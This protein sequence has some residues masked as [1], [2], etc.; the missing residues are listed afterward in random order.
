MGPLLILL[1]GVD[2]AEG[3]TPWDNEVGTDREAGQGV[4][5]VREVGQ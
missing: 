3:E 2:E 5:T 1:D 4:G